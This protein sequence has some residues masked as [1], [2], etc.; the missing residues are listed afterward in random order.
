MF[1]FNIDNPL[2]KLHKIQSKVSEINTEGGSGGGDGVD[3]IKTIN[4]ATETSLGVVQLSGVL[5]GTAT[6]PE[7]SFNCVKS[8][9]LSEECV[10]YN[11]I[12][13]LS[14]ASLLG[15][16]T[17]SGGNITEVELN[18]GLILENGKLSL[19]LPSIIT[20]SDVMATKSELGVITLGDGG[21]LN[22]SPNVNL[23]ENGKISN[24]PVIGLNKVTYPKIQKVT[25]KSLLGNSSIFDD[26]VEEIKIKNGLV[27]EDSSLSLDVNTLPQA[28]STTFG[29]IKLSGDLSGNASSPTI[30]NQSITSYKLAPLPKHTILGSLDNTLSPTPISLHKSL[31]VVN[32]QLKVNPKEIQSTTDSLGTIMLS[33]DLTGTATNPEISEKSITYS[34]MQ[35]VNGTKVLLGN[36]SGTGNISEIEVGDSLILKNGF[37]DVDLDKL[38]EESILKV[39]S[40]G[41]GNS[42]L[43]LGYLKGKEKDPVESVQ[44]IPVT[45]IFPNV[46]GSVN[47]VFPSKPGGNISLIFS[48]V[49]TGILSEIPSRQV[50]GTIYIISGDPTPTNNG[51]TFISDGTNWNE[52][53]NHLG[54]TDAR[55]V[56]LAGSTMSEDAS[57]V[58]P[59]TS[60]II[61][62]QTSFSNKD[63]VT[64]EYV[65][66][67]KI[68]DATVSSKG[69]LELSG[70]FDSLSTADNPIIKSATPTVKGKIQLAGDFDPLSTSSLP[71]IKAASTTSRGKIQLSG[72]FDP[73]STSTNPIIKSATVH[74]EGK[75]QLSGDFDSKSTSQFPLIKEASEVHFGKIKLAGDLSGNADAPEIAHNAITYSKIQQASQK[76]IIGNAINGATDIGE[77]VIGNGLM[78]SSGGSLPTVGTLS[79]DS[80]TLP[81][82]TLN[83]YGSIQLNGDFNPLSTAT[84]PMIGEG[85]ITYKK[86]QQISSQ[87]KLLGSA[88]LPIGIQPI[89]EI[90]VGP[91]LTYSGAGNNILNAS[92]SFFSGTN[93]NTSPPTDRPTTSNLL[94]IGVDGSVW[95][96]NGVHYSKGPGALNVL[97]SKNLYT[98]GPL[99]T[100]SPLSM[101]D[102]DI[103]VSA[104]QRIKIKYILN[105]QSTGGAEYAP[106]FGWNGVAQ[107]DF[108][109][110]SIIGF[111]S[112]SNTSSSFSTIYQTNT[113]F[114]SSSR[115]VTGGANLFALT[116]TNADNNLLAWNVGTPEQ[117]L[118]GIGGQAIP[119]YIT[120]YYENNTN[121][122]TILEIV[123]NRDLKTQ[124]GQ[125]IQIAGGVADYVTY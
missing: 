124:T 54:S 69:I 10:Q 47:G 91:S 66:E 113:S 102:F 11:H 15:Q 101:S 31:G 87:R 52:V 5:K 57:L 56:Q 108:F 109:Q 59:S 100:P 106:S 61:L 36:L 71:L 85:K 122:E 26:N 24:D 60:N 120:A 22:G 42:V 55:Y 97:K 35:S 6:N 2:H 37:L 33:G 81:K 79:V 19:D 94:Y 53:T 63:A 112:S 119:I 64:K 38:H 114:T 30:K 50:N 3:E 88:S 73:L 28:S 105:F 44:K 27:L 82:A 62:N 49:T 16:T 4:P 25:G 20:L 13:K 95:M 118:G 121:K 48:N 12:Q 29:V 103:K 1:K 8:N 74:S 90:S 116:S 86:M 83:S 17:K 65:D 92:T 93:P 23:L 9:H 78:L 58:F 98:I 46:V 115:Q 41:T 43:P 107:E 45:D 104:G 39:E 18:S 96:W 111:F 51:R 75:I 77:V 7:L 67:I 72:D 14:K 89:Q 21:D 110:A 34:K 70:D 40:G 84:A 32:E 80:N 76:S 125:T 117:Q 68:N 99:G 123:F